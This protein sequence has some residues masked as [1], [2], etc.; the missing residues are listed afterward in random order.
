MSDLATT[1]YIVDDDLPVLRA[2]VRLVTAH[3]YHATGF[4]DAC[5][6]LDARAADA[7]PACVVLDL[8]MPGMDGIGLQRELDGALPIIFITGH[9][10]VP[11]AILALRAGAAD[12]LL[13][14][15]LETALLASLDRACRCA[16][17]RHREHAEM[18]GLRERLDRLTPREREVM[19]WVVTGR[20]NKQ[21]ASELGTVEKTI[22]AH[23]ASV[24]RKLEVGSLPELVRL[25]DK[26][27]LPPVAA[28]PPAHRAGAG[29]W[30]LSGGA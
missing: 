6:F 5:T 1:V 20:L 15:I 27:G 16:V 10:D 26:V 28:A 4:S 9:A 29:G 21:V 18:A 7:G 11:S 17:A 22:K 2:L 23:R 12:F 30:S 13:K 25:A 19:A 24:M 8:Q 3:G 14:P